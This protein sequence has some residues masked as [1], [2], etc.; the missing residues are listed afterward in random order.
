[1]YYHHGAR[2]HRDLFV[3]VLK[4]LH[5]RPMVETELP[6]A[7]RISLLHQPQRNR[8]VAHLL[9]GPPSQRGRCEVIED[10]PT[11]TDVSLSF[12]LPTSIKRIA[13]HNKIYTKRH[14]SA[15]K[16]RFSLM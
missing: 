1:M 6:S 13:F 12:D 16:K 3:N 11:L 5:T 4:L 14:W 9:Y 10:L 15:L 2:L 8:Y 7:G